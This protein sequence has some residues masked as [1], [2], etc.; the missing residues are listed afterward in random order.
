[1]TPNKL[2][3]IL[4]GL[5]GL[6]VLVLPDLRAGASATIY[7]IV[8]ISIAALSYGVGL[9]YIRKSLIEMPSFQVPAAQL[10]S[11]SLYLLPLGFWTSPA[12]NWLEVSTPVWLAVLSLGLFGTAIAYIIYFK[13]LRRT[14]AAF[15]SLVTYLMP[16]YGVFLGAIFFT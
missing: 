15:V 7:G 6:F 14:N 5:I 10:L 4:L 13:L 12:F 8:A 11:I 3:G 16:L 2:K 1:M 9:V